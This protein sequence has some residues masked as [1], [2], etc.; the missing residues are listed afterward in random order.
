MSQKHGQIKAALG[1][2]MVNINNF[3]CSIWKNCHNNYRQLLISGV[4]WEYCEI[5]VL[6]HHASVF[7]IGKNPITPI[8]FAQSVTLSVLSVLIGWSSLRFLS[9]GDVCTSWFAVRALR[10]DSPLL[11]AECLQATL[12]VGS[13]LSWDEPVYSTFPATVSSRSNWTK[14]GSDNKQNKTRARKKKRRSKVGF[15]W[16]SCYS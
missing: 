3:L 10:S 5:S 1:N 11:T 4:V 12:S 16:V 14:G 6:S 7:R 15:Q 2:F 9:T 13:S 8:L